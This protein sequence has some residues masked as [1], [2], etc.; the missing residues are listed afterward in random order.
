MVLRLTISAC[1]GGCGAVNATTMRQGYIRSFATVVGNAVTGRVH[2]RSGR[3]LGG[4]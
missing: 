1:P 3:L 2:P 4:C